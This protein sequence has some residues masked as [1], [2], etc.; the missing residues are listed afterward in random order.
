MKNYFFS[1]TAKDVRGV[2]QMGNFEA[3][4]DQLTFEAISLIV[5]AYCEKRQREAGIVMRPQ[6]FCVTFFK[7]LDR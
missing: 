4:T 2:I 1:F 7:E 3:K 6:E 5:I